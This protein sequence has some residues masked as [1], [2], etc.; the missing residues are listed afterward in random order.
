MC[1]CVKFYYLFIFLFWIDAVDTSSVVIDY[2]Q[3]QINATDQLGRFVSGA[4]IEI[5]TMNHLHKLKLC[6]KNSHSILIFLTKLCCFC[7]KTWHNKKRERTMRNK[8]GWFGTA[9]INYFYICHWF[10]IWCNGL[11]HDVGIEM[12]ESEFASLLSFFFVFLTRVNVTN[13]NKF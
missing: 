5:M 11:G 8:C 13:E 4:D 10:Q 7:L 9:N 1:A 12:N 6:A 3:Q 2:K